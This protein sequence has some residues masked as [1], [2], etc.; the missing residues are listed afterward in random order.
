[1]TIKKAI[2]RAWTDTEYKTKL[3]SDPHAALAEAGIDVPAGTTIKFIEDTADTHHI[4]LPVAPTE[5]GKFSMNELEKVAGG[6]GTIQPDPTGV[7]CDY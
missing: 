5:A 7:V 1:M 4:V 2:A 6:V 3:L